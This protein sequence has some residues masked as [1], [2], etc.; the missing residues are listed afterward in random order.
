MDLFLLLALFIGILLW[1][2]CSPLGV[3]VVLPE[4]QQRSGSVGGSVWSH[5][6]YGAYIR[7]RSIPVNPNTDRQVAVRNIVRSLSIAW[8]LTLTQAQRDAWN[9]YAAN[10]AWLD[11]LG[12]SVYLTGLNHYIRS[13]TPRLQAIAPRIDDAPVIFNLATAE[14]ALSATASEATQ[15]ATVHFDDTAAWAS[16]DGAFQFLFGGRPQNAAIKFFGGPYR[17][18]PGIAGNATTPPTS[19]HLVTW[20]FPFAED[21]RLWLRTRIGR[22]DGRLSEFAQVNFLAGP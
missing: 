8:Q 7:A 11:P 3:K 14:L 18:M 12:Q 21:N 22:A 17:S 6:R 15:Q 5:N 2:A 20:P 9:V 4:G 10:V 13:N 16:E 19:P 1:L